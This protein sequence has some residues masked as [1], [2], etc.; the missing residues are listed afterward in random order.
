MAR[1]LP[2]I[3]I[4]MTDLKQRF[5]RDIGYSIIVVVKAGKNIMT[6]RGEMEMKELKKGLISLKI[7]VMA[8]LTVLGAVSASFGQTIEQRLDDAI[9]EITVLKRVLVE[10]D[11]RITKLEKEISAAKQFSVVPIQKQPGVSGKPSEPQTT[12]ALW[13]DPANWERVIEGMSK[14]QVIAILGKPTSTENLGGGHLTLFYRGEVPGS[15]SVSGNVKL[16]E[17]RVSF[18]NKPVF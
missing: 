10:Q 11:R 6:E 13:H 3:G 18:V 14:S 1:A 7:F 9:A 5:L 15:G 12:G 16:Y 17:D 4:K 8:G 2:R